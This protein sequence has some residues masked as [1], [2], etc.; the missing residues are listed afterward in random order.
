VLDGGYALAAGQAGALLTRT[1]VRL[2][3]RVS[4]LCI[5]GGGLWLALSRRA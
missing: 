5:I 2:V 4:G 3:E 1:R